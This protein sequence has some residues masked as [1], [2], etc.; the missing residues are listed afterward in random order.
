[1]IK[2]WPQKRFGEVCNFVRGPFGG[3]LKKSIFKDE[4]YAVYEQQHAINDQFSSIRYFVDQN[5]FDEMRRFELFPDDLIMSC[6]GTMGKIAIVPAGIPRGVINQALL[7][8]T[9][10]DKL[11]P[12]F[13][14]FWMESR[15]FQE[16]IKA[17]SQGVAIKNMASVKVLK[18]IKVPTPSPEIQKSIVVKLVQTFADIEKAKFNAKQNLVNAKALFES[19]LQG[20][21]SHSQE[22]WAESSLQEITSKIGSG[23]T[24]RGGKAAYKEQGMSL[25]R[26]MNVHDR[27]FKEKN[28]ALID[29]DQAAKLNNVTIEKDDVLLNITGASVARCCVVPSEYLPARVNQ[30]VS[31]IR[32]N[33]DIISPRFL[34][35]LL[36]SIYYKNILLEVGGSGA[37]REAIT[38]V[39]LQNFI[40]T[41]PDTIKKQNEF[42]DELAGIESKSIELQN[43]YIKKIQALDELKQSILQKAFNGELA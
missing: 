14:K 19:Y 40:I 27:R 13:L 37:T 24:P 10:K 32:V 30:H 11:L 18:E 39:Q 15:N 38:K 34:C 1:M 20:I 33:K 26:S 35:F 2:N 4:G 23:A 41:Y 25:I 28:L 12:T 5:K 9:P 43:V 22:G 42:L 29:D 36:T 7:K 31:I 6:S 8:I 3:S 21:F 16:Q 17:L